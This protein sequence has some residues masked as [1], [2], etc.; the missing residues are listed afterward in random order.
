MS[1]VDVIIP[2]Y[3]TPIEY[4]KAAI[5]SVIAQTFP[6]WTIVLVNDGSRDDMSAAIEKTIASFNDKRVTYVKQKNKGLSAARNAGIRAS[7][8]PYVALLDSDDLWHPAKLALQVPFMDANPRVGVVHSGSNRLLTD[9][10][11]IPHDTKNDAALAK[12]DLEAA[13]FKMAR[14][15]YVAGVNSILMRRSM[16]DQVGHFDENFESVEDKELYLRFMLNGHELVFLPGTVAIYRW[17]DD[18]M[19]KNVERMKAGRLR[20]VAKV[21]ELLSESGRFKGPKWDALKRDM[22]HHVY[23]EAAFTAYNQNEYRKAFLYSLPHLCGVTY[24]TVKLTIKSAFKAI[25]G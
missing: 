18:N 15:N 12:L 19:S 10:T 21:D 4:T 3:N 17:H 23:I 25:V 16:L 7:N 2:Y 14:Q 24:P 13:F 20:L 11:I 6:D 22:R 8:S 1:K 5:E 9:G